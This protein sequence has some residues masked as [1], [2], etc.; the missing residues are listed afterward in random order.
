MDFLEKD[1]ENIIWESNNEKLQEKGLFISGKK[2]RQLR[3]GNY[4]IA[5]L[6][7]F[8]RSY[9]EFRETIPYL[10]ITVFELKKDKAGISAFLQA[11]KYCQGIKTYLT[12]YKP[13][14]DFKLNIVLCS[15]NIDTQTDYIYLCNLLHKSI[16]SKF[17]N[18]LKNY[19]FKFSIDG[20]E[21]NEESGYD[22]K[23]KGF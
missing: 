11:V 18:S 1:L 20:I 2:Y 10:D 19:S 14:I 21:F 23:N 17:L 12:E 3:I 5:D 22:L 13:N 7:T 9:Y 4:G 8:D 16:D 6:V 15:K